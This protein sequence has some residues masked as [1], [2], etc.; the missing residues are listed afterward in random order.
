MTL[1]DWTS[2]PFGV[3]KVQWDGRDASGNIIDNRKILIHI[4]ANDQAFSGKHQEHDGSVCRD[5]KLVIETDQKNVQDVKG[6]LRMVTR[7]F[8]NSDKEG[9]VEGCE[10]RYYVDYGLVKKESFQTVPDEFALAIDTTKLSNGEHFITVN[11][12]DN[13]DHVGTASIKFSITN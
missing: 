5:P 6:N 11:I 9:W 8:E 13:N 12:S 1:Q 10:V 3:Y 4:D 2:Q 7:F